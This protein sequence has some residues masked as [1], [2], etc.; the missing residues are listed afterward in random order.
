[1][2]LEI[3][4]VGSLILNGFQF[5]ERGELV[6]SNKQ[7]QQVTTEQNDLI[8]QHYI[9]V[10]KLEEEL[11]QTQ[12]AR[13]EIYARS[14]ERA[15]ELEKLRSTNVSVSVYLNQDIPAELVE[16]LQDNSKD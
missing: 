2:L 1:M 12:K 8:N 3:L 5:Q 11:V 4:L 7:L 14:E 9:D 16:H 10:D 13:E 6:Q 15:V